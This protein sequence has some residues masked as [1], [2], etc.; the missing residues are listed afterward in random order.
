MSDASQYRAFALRDDLADPDVGFDYGVQIALPSGAEFKVGEALEEGNGV[1]VTADPM[2]IDSLRAWSAVEDVDL[3]DDFVPPADPADTGPSLA[4]LK[5]RA[6]ELDI[7][8]R[9]SM[10]KE[11]LASAIADAEAQAQVTDDSGDGGT[12]EDDNGTEG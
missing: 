2:K 3:P 11:E 8:G 1:I 12:P 5:A 10:N 7:D 9:S 6:S 4:D